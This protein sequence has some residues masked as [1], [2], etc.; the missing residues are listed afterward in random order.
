MR[1]KTN[2]TQTFIFSLVW[3]ASYTLYTFVTS[4]LMTTGSGFTNPYN[5]SSSFMPMCFNAGLLGFFL[6][7]AAGTDAWRK[8]TKKEKVRQRWLRRY[9]HR[10]IRS[11]PIA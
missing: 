5:A 7:S 11:R 2:C 10:P 3:T 6:L 4:N 1:S 9:T 8:M